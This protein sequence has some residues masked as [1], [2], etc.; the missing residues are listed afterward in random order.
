MFSASNLEPIDYILLKLDTLYLL[1]LC[2]EL[3]SKSLL[4]L[5]TL[6]TYN[7]FIGNPN[8]KRQ[9]NIDLLHER[10]FYDKFS[11]LKI[12]QAFKR[13]ARSYKIEIIDSKDPLVQLV[14]SKSSIKDLFIDLLDE[15][16]GFT[17]QIT[18]KIL[19]SKRKGNR[20][21]GFAPFYF[22][23]TTKTV[24]NLEYDLDKSF[25]EIL[26]RID[27]WI[28]EISG[29]VTESIDAEYGNISIFSP[30]SGSS[31]IEL[32]RRLRNSMKGLINIKNND[33]KCFLWCHIRH[34]NPLKLHPE[35]ITKADKNMA[36]NFDYE[37]IEF[38]VSKKDFSK[39]E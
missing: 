12:L 35:R 27:N 2:T 24:I 6:L 36:K 34:L 32:P 29:C 38:P 20:E 9:K 14:T 26:H 31:Y 4:Y 17:Y 19:L 37:D 5:L 18:V 7:T 30:L 39:I 10:S 11:I 22:N 16:K 13:Y 23:S 33:N 8:I 3:Y 15:M 1:K 28:N 25:Q 21:I